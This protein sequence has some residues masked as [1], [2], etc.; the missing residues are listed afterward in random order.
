[1]NRKNVQMRTMLRAATVGFLCLAVGAV[2]GCRVLGSVDVS[3]TPW[4]GTL[5]PSEGAP[6]GSVA[7]LS[8]SGVTRASIQITGGRQEGGVYQWRIRTGSCGQP[9]VVIGGLA[10]YPDLDHESAGTTTA[11]G[12]LSE[13]MPEGR[14]YHAVLIRAADAVEVACG[15]LQRV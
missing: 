6:T 8:Q 11:D 5:V 12:V 4:E 3:V 10:Q 14:N 9:G 13:P 2:P 7:A 1:M 15:Q